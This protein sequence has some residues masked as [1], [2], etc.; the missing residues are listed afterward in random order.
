MTVGLAA[1]KQAVIET[2][3]VNFGLTRIGNIDYEERRVVS[4]KLQD[5]VLVENGNDYIDRE[6]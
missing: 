6:D 4:E 5:V 2:L 3:R 1:G